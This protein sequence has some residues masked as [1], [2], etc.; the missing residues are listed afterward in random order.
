MHADN[1]E[2]RFGLLS[3]IG[4]HVIWGVFPL[5]WR[6]FGD[7]DALQVVAHRVLWAFV[8]L[9][10]ALPLLRAQLDARQRQEL[11]DASRSPRVW[12]TYTMA[13]GLIAVNWLTFIWAVNHDRVL[14]ASLG[15]YI[16]PLLNVLLGVWVLGER[17]HRLQWIAIGFAA[18]G[19]AIMT[20]GERG[21]PWPSLVLAASFSLYSLVKKRAP[22]TALIGLLFETTALLLPALTYLVLVERGVMGP[23]GSSAFAVGDLRMMVLLVLGGTVTIFPLGLFAFAARRVKLTTL[24][25]LQYIGPTM[26]FLIGTWVLRETFDS[27]GM[28]GFSA[29][30]LALILYMLSLRGSR[31]R[32]VAAERARQ[33]ELPPGARADASPFDCRGR[34]GDGKPSAQEATLEDEEDPCCSPA[35]AR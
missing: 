35:S 10:A 13:A 16:N 19:V 34:A 20:L 2:V 14:D 26:Q 15:Y 4:A 17:L 8:A 3:A 25:I 9:L 6:Q 21:L 27:W 30:W 11:R 24:G 18:V 1:R 23:A 29:V 5:F 33:R 22:L 28:M 31:S 7:Y 32:G 12:A